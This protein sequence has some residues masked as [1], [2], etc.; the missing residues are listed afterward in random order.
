MN[1]S[2]RTSGIKG[3][4]TIFKKARED[5]NCGYHVSQQTHVQ[6]WNGIIVF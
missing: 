4:R 5:P 3:A 2:R 1:F 6:A